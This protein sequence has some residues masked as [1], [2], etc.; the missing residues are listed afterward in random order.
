MN[1]KP[2]MLSRL[3]LYTGNREYSCS[4]NSARSS[5]MVAVL[6]HGDDIGPRRHH[7]AHQRVAEVHDALEELALFALDEPLLFGRVDERLRGVVGRLGRFVRIARRWRRRT[8]RRRDAAGH[9]AGQRS[10]GVRDRR[11]RRQQQLEHALRVA[12]DNDER[13][14]Q[15]EHRDEHDDAHR[16]E[17]HRG[18]ALDADAR[19]QKSR[20]R[21]RSRARAENE[22][23]RTAAADRP[24]R[25]PARSGRSLRS[26]ASRSDSRISAL[27]AASMAPR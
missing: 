24:G 4:R 21:R 25:R 2:A 8:A 16:D 7:L 6:G 23:A 19:G 17:R 26:A 15:L 14:Q 12:A 3:S 1:T 5:P 27:N 9:P 18:R 22:P 10:D 13:Q 11:K 20:R